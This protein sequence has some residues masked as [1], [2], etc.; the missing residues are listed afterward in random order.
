[1]LYGVPGGLQQCDRS[2]GEVQLL[3]VVEAVWQAVIAVMGADHIDELR[4]LQYCFGFL[5]PAAGDDFGGVRIAGYVYD[6][7]GQG[8]G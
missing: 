8:D 6:A 2:L 7:V 3:F 1:M 4:A 5:V